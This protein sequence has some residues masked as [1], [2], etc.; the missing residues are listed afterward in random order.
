[1]YV[2]LNVVPLYVIK[3]IQIRR[4]HLVIVPPEAVSDETPTPRL[5]LRPWNTSDDWSILLAG[6]PAHPAELTQAV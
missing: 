2:V 1:M 3:L 4:L 6:E 5:V